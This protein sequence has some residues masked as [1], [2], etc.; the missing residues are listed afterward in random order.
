MSEERDFVDD[1]LDRA[2]AVRGHAEPRSGLDGRI[3]ATLRA[4]PALPRWKAV[5]AGWPARTGLAAA[6][7]AGVLA[8]LVAGRGDRAGNVAAPVVAT[9]PSQAASAQAEG[10]SNPSIQR[11]RAP[12]LVPDERPALPV[13]LVAAA[14]TK[15]HPSFP[16]ESPLSD[17]ERLLLLYVSTVPREE[18]EPRAGFLD[19][20]A[21]LPALPDPTTEP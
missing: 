1:V 21:P 5:L 20:P 9:L 6:A 7:L 16:R 13:R 12:V 18:I 8:V 10:P 15:R 17:Q 19:T 14:R 11:N 3:L 4:R 2:L